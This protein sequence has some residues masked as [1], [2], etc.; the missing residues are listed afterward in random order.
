M[1]PLAR[2]KKEQKALPTRTFLHL[3]RVAEHDNL[4]RNR[5]ASSFFKRNPKTLRRA[6]NRAGI[7]FSNNA[8]L[9]Q[10]KRQKDRLGV[11]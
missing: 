5:Q 3:R 9:R 8:S 11:N 6:K 1:R 4:Y 10:R 7:D 2:G